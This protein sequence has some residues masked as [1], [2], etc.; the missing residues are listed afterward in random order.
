MRGR[1]GR[2]GRYGRSCSRGAHLRGYSLLEGE[3]SAPSIEE[4]S[5][6][7]DR[8][9]SRCRP[10]VRAR[11]RVGGLDMAARCRDMPGTADST[12]VTYR[13]LSNQ[14]SVYSFDTG[15]GRD[16]PAHPDPAGRTWVISLHGL[17]RKWYRSPRR[18]R[19]RIRDAVHRERQHLARRTRAGG[20][21]TAAACSCPENSDGFPIA[22]VSIWRMFYD[23]GKVSPRWDDAE[24]SKA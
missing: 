21:V 11:V 17:R 14:D 6:P 4:D 5:R 13:A 24:I 1:G 20:F 18:T 15:P 8:A 23:T 10:E 7:G 9:Q 3:G 16:R 19:C 22:W 12:R 2:H